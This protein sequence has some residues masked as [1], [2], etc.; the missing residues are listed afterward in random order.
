L[1]GPMRESAAWEAPD[2]SPKAI[3][4]TAANFLKAF[5]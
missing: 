2:T 5:T 3:N 1:M 4:D